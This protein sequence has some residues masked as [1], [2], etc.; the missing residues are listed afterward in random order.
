[1]IFPLVQQILGRER[2]HLAPKVTGM[3]VDLEVMT[4]EEIIK[5]LQNHKKL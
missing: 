3:L 1:M 4:V 2:Q 5:L